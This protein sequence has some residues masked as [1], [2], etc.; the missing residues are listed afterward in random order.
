MGAP[1]VINSEAAW[2]E[3]IEASG[4]NP[5]IA[6]F[7]APWCISSKKVKPTFQ[8]LAKKYPQIQFLDVDI[9]EMQEL[10]GEMGLTSI[11][12]V[13]FYKEGVVIETCRLSEQTSKKLLRRPKN[14]CAGYQ[15]KRS[16]SSGSDGQAL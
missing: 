16:C 1:V 14:M 2:T 12:A 8:A 11:P 6:M 13:F 15:G 4:K 10:A 5:F 9:D 3:Y 7:T